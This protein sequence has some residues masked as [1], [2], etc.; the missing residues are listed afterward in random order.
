MHDLKIDFEENAIFCA[1]MEAIQIALYKA[2]SSYVTAGYSVQSS[3]QVAQVI[4]CNK[5]ISE[6]Q[7]WKRRIKAL[8]VDW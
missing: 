1:Q 8:F 4:Q 7:W 5:C 2:P 3:D 6:D